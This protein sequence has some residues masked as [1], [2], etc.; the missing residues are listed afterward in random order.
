MF[1]IP[2]ALQVTPPAY[3]KRIYHWLGYALMAAAPLT[4]VGVRLYPPLG[5]ANPWAVVATLLGLAVSSPVLGLCEERSPQGKK[6]QHGLAT[7]QGRAVYSDSRFLAHLGTNLLGALAASTLWWAADSA[8][9]VAG[10]LETFPSAD[11]ALSVMLPLSALVVFQ[12]V[13]SQQMDAL[14]KFDSRTIKEVMR[15][16]PKKGEAKIVGFSLRHLH[17][18]ANVFHLVA[19][20]FVASCSYLFLVAYAIEKSAGEHPPLTWPVVAA[21]VLT[22]CFV[23]VC[24]APGLRGAPGPRDNKA[25]YLTFLT[26]APAAMGGAMLWLAWFQGGTFRDYSIASIAV[27]GYVLFCIEAV[28]ADWARDERC[29]KEHRWPPL[30]HFAPM[31]IAVVLALLLFALIRFTRVF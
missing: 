5:H 24:G 8:L 14:S 26:G 20:T 22:L 4:Y 3:P 17:Q 7:R 23:Y 21:I 30:H 1:A 18:L 31:T 9:G 15:K 10:P 11:V 19:A 16:D 29:D 2:L 12:F 25:V 13:R 27:V 28:M 6:L